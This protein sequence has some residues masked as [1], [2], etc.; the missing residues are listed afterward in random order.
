V[1]LFVWHGAGVLEDYT[2]G[3]I[4]ALASDLGGAL[5][6][7]EAECDWAEGGFPSIPTEIVDLGECPDV[8]QRA[9]VVWGGGRG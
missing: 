1:K 6:A 7:I 9:W 4:V 5:A 3:Q 2:Y 8:Q